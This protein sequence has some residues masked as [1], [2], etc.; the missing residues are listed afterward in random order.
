MRYERAFCGRLHHGSFLAVGP[1]AWDANNSIPIS[2]VKRERE[3]ERERKK[4]DWHR[5]QRVYREIVPVIIELSSWGM[6]CLHTRR[7][8]C[9]LLRV[10]AHPVVRES[11]RSKKKDEPINFE[12]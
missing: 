2:T 11:Q 9:Q 8:C 4:Y 1:S 12:S 10:A 7:V 6:P 5:R 3:R